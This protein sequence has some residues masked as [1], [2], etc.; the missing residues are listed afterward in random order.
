MGEEIAD[1][2]PVPVKDAVRQGV[3]LVAVQWVLYHL[4]PGRA[5]D[6][7]PFLRELWEEDAFALWWIDGPIPVRESKLPRHLLVH[8]P[9][10]VIEP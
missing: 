8:R 6:V 10:G 3:K 5:V 2:Y 7:D 9:F 4:P 1:A